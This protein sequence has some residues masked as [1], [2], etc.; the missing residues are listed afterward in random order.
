MVADAVNM[1][2]DGL[3]DL[4]GLNQ[5]GMDLIDSSTAVYDENLK[6]INSLSSTLQ[7][8][9]TN[10]IESLCR[11]HYENANYFKDILGDLL[12]EGKDDLNVYLTSDE[13]KNNLEKSKEYLENKE[14]IDEL[15][16]LINGGTYFIDDPT[17]GLYLRDPLTGMYSYDID[18]IK[19]SISLKESIINRFINT[20]SL[21]IYRK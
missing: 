8:R 3:G 21:F 4:S 10:T 14:E 17:T 9:M 19:Q 12:K 20:F 5:N 18:R 6:S 11:M 1:L 15:Y 2:E 16:K 7:H 13:Y